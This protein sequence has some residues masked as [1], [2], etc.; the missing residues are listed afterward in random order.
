MSSRP[1]DPTRPSLGRA[2][3]P[4]VW[5]QSREG[6]LVDGRYRIERLL[7][8]GGMGEVYV[9][10]QLSMGRPVAL[11]LLRL[12]LA[13]RPQARERFY[14]EA[15]AASRLNHPN[16]VTVY[17]FGSAKE[18]LFMAMELVNGDALPNVLAEGPLEW[19]RAAR[20][21]RSVADALTHAHANEV[22]HCDIKTENL[23][24]VHRAQR[25]EHLKILDF[26]IARL[27]TATSTLEQSGG[28]AVGT[29]M[30]M[31]PEVILGELA[32]PQADIY[33]L[34][35][36][37]FEL[38]SG[39]QPFEHDNVQDLVQKK[40]FKAPRE[41]TL[42]GVSA[43]TQGALRDLVLWM[44]APRPDLRP[45]S[46]E[47]VRERL[48]KL[49]EPDTATG[50]IVG[51]PAPGME[52]LGTPV[53]SAVPHA[54]ANL[55]VLLDALCASPDLPVFATVVQSIETLCQGT[56]AAAERDL[57][58]LLN[59]IGL[60]HKLLQVANSPFYRGNHPEI[61]RISRAVAVMGLEQV[62][63]VAMSLPLLN[64]GDAEREPAVL[65]SALQSLAS[66]VM[67]KE[68]AGQAGA[69]AED[70][71]LG[72]LMRNLG[73]HLVQ[74]RF[75]ELA[76][77]VRDRATELSEEDACREVLGAT[78]EVLTQR[79]AQRM[80]F[81]VRLQALVGPTEAAVTDPETSS[82]RY[83]VLSVTGDKVKIRDRQSKKTGLAAPADLRLYMRF[84]GGSAS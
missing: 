7:G 83:E 44:M 69:N 37:L 73:R 24:L 9:A 82:G 58:K 18:G 10:Q 50:G 25:G 81:P 59:E 32:S 70:A 55:G 11:K 53:P 61:T 13:K 8:V 43:A 17:D 42:P 45:R 35:V 54:P 62:R 21:L 67:A 4:A 51:L 79:I 29:P 40:L 36:V 28:P 5:Q 19:R 56:G 31:A 65:E 15:R 20:L 57:E 64:T 12:E 39:M 52:P 48:D 14:S 6:Q 78:W 63:R 38:L 3:A 27:A 80:N 1:P 84:G 22:I 23:M 60:A 16:I 2:P 77:R 76:Q 71:S 30:A 46:C 26:G 41:F 66:A 72:A 68:L 75:P 74:V 33:S 47:R 34:G 49:L